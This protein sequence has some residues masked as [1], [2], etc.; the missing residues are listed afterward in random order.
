NEESRSAFTRV[1]DV[2]A[3]GQVAESLR[4]FPIVGLDLETTGL[5]PRRDRVR[6]LSQATPTTP[7]LVDCFAVDP[8]PLFDALAACPLVAH[9]AAFDLGMLW[10]LGF[11][12]GRVADTMVLSQLLY[13][14]R[15]P[16]GF[17]T[18]AACVERELSRPL[19]KGLQSSDWSGDL[20]PEQLA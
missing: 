6:L 18:L 9:N 14:T 11:R 4:E 5:D 8:S 1:G 19:P 2:A 3:M 17:H 10:K 15:Q 16:R 20:S 7:W 13:G 12:P